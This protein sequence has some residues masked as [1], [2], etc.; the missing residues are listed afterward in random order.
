MK[1]Y[2]KPIRKYYKYVYTP[3]T[4]PLASNDNWFW[5]QNNDRY[6]VWGSHEAGAAYCAFNGSLEPDNCWWTNH[7]VT[8]S[9]NWCALYFRPYIRLKLSQVLIRNENRTPENFKHGWLQG[10]DNVNDSWVNIVELFGVNAGDAVMTF[11]VPNNTPVYPQYRL[12]FDEA[13][14]TAGVSIQIVTYSGQQESIVAG[15]ENDYDFYVDYSTYTS[16]PHIKQDKLKNIPNIYYD[17]THKLLKNNYLE[18]PPGSNCL[19]ISHPTVFPHTAFTF[20]KNWE[21]Q[22]KIL[23]T[24][25]TDLFFRIWHLGDYYRAVDW[26]EY[27][28]DFRIA[29]GHSPNRSWTDHY[30]SSDG[31]PF[32]KWVWIRLR[33]T[34][35]HYVCSQSLDGITY[36]DKVAF[37]HDFD[38]PFW[39][40]QLMEGVK[41][42]IDLNESYLKQWTDSEAKSEYWWRGTRH[43]KV[44]DT[45]SYDALTRNYTKY[46]MAGNYGD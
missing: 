34:G 27:N 21:F 31:I 29:T 41:G 3:W 42:V 37:D 20:Y 19:W 9:T 18:V 38:W 46:E 5:G 15:T 30:W 40:I 33:K 17:S 35:A 22:L 23:R 11:T 6:V 16:C 45:S 8:S 4:Q 14:S 1:C 44:L 10:Y 2:S 7:G 39:A 43:Q 26:Y 36:R 13:Y 12:Y 24:T 32:D 25:G 28:G